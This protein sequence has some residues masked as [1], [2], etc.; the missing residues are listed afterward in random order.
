MDFLL[1]LAALVALCLAPFIGIGAFLFIALM[2]G[3]LTIAFGVLPLALFGISSLVMKAR[4]LKPAGAAQ[5]KD[6]MANWLKMAGD[7]WNKRPR[8]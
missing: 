5:A 6:T 1:V 8:T 3:L 4:Q 7:A 2:I